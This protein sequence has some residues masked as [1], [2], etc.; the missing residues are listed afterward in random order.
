MPLQS[1]P[2]ATSPQGLCTNQLYLSQE[3]CSEK[4]NYELLSSN[5]SDYSTGVSSTGSTYDSDVSYI[6]GELFRAWYFVKLKLPTL[7]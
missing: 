2:A 7:V 6:N 1:P 3:T 4:M 5:H